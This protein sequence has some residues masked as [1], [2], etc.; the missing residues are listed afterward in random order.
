M[1][2]L[3]H[4]TGTQTYP[5]GTKYDGEFAKGFEHGQGHKT[6]LSKEGQ[7]SFTG[8]FRFGRK[9]GPGTMVHVDGTTE[10]GTFLDPTEKYTE[11]SPPYIRRK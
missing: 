4:G 1:E 7:S 8:R 9:D 10:K 5:D 3:K 6:Y 2:G 11:K